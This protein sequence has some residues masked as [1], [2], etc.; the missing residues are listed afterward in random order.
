M[1]GL[2]QQFD[3]V[4][5]LS[6][7]V[8]AGKTVVPLVG[9]GFSVDSGIPTLSSLTQYL[10]KVQCY[11]ANEVFSPGA[12]E[13]VRVSVGSDETRAQS[14][15]DPSLYIRDIGWPDPHRMNAELWTWLE[16]QGRGDPRHRSLLDRQVQAAFIED[17]ARMDSGLADLLG[18]LP[19]W[20]RDLALKGNWKSLLAHL[21]RT[22]PD[23]VDTLFQ[24]LLKGRQPGTAH[25]FLAFLAPVLGLRLFLT[26]NF[27]DLLEQALRLAGLR[28]IVY[29][30]SRDS[31]LPHPSLIRQ[32]LSVVKL[33]GGA[34]GLRVGEELDHPL[35]EDSKR[36]LEQYLGDD[37]ILLVM[38]VGGWDRRVM[39]FVELVG[40]HPRSSGPAVYWMHFEPRCPTPIADL[41]KKI[42]E[43]RGVSSICPVRTYGPGAFLQELYY[44]IT[45]SHPPSVHSYDPYTTR[46]VDAFEHRAEGAESQPIH[47]FLDDPEDL[48]LDASLR[49]GRF[50][51]SKASTHV[52][53]WVD[54][55]VMHTLADVVAEIFRQIR[56]YDRWLSPIVL[57]TGPSPDDGDEIGKAVRRTYTALSRGRYILAFNAVGS[58]G[59]PPTYHHGFHERPG[60]D[61]RFF[62]ELFQA[63]H[64]PTE[65]GWIRPEHWPSFCGPLRDSILAF[66]I[67]PLGTRSP[68][69]ARDQTSGLPELYDLVKDADSPLCEP[70]HTPEPTDQ[71]RRFAAG[72]REVAWETEDFEILL[73]LAAFRRRRSIVALRRLIPA[74]VP[75]ELRGHRG[76]ALDAAVDD[77]LADL[78]KKGFVKRLEGGSYWMSPRMR[79]RIYELGQRSTDSER[80]AETIRQREAGDGT[81]AEPGIHLCRLATIHDQIADFY[82]AELFAAS[83]E[84]AALLECLYH[85][86]SSLRY[87]T[88][89]DVWL[90]G[91]IETLP[92]EAADRLRRYLGT[93]KLPAARARRRLRELRLRSLRSIRAVVAREREHLLSEVSTDTLIGWLEWIRD[94][95]L[96]RFRVDSCLTVENPPEPAR[97]GQREW[98]LEEAIEVECGE[99]RTL[100]DDLVA[101]ALRGKMDFAGCART[102]HRR[103]RLLLAPSLPD[104]ETAPPA[105]L[106][107][108]LVTIGQYVRSAEV[109]GRRQIVTA[110]CDLW[111]CLR[112]SGDTHY[113]DAVQGKWRGLVDHGSE[114]T[115]LDRGMEALRL[116]FLRAEAEHHLMGLSP[117]TDRRAAVPEL[118]ERCA[119]AFATCDEALQLITWATWA[120]DADYEREKSYFHSLKGRAHY[121]LRQ[122]TEAFREIDLS[123]MGLAPAIGAD[124]EVLAV[125]LLR[126]TE[127]LM[128]RSDQVFREVPAADGTQEGRGQAESRA[129]RHLSRAHD[130][131]E[132]AAEMMTGARQDVE[133]W[134]CLYQLRAQLQVEYLLLQICE[135]GEG[136]Q[137]RSRR[138]SAAQF[139]ERLRA[140]LRAIRQGLDVVPR[141]DRREDASL[142]SFIVARLLQAWVELMVCSAYLTRTI[143]RDP[144]ITVQDLWR[145]WRS[146]NEW[147][148]LRCCRTTG[149][150]FQ[151]LHE[152]SAP[153]RYDTGRE[154][155]DAAL[156][157]SRR[158]M[159]A[160]S[161]ERLFEAFRESAR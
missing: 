107:I 109:E 85:R 29:E 63:A 141:L 142:P 49:L 14:T 95:D 71:A 119:R 37:S 32:D 13:K 144:R 47:I 108:D 143:S 9:A 52:P 72:D 45:S 118:S 74:C 11:I 106:R 128:V 21:T 147:S 126:L 53:I 134:A 102:R 98:L 66:S 159:D 67:D 81:I 26:I 57:P 10:A 124:R 78:E 77:R 161:I 156:A 62:W 121:L 94:K 17:L 31:P 93:E 135:L 2:E 75:Q 7:E 69:E 64:R 139:T 55:E 20:T 38:G 149:D 84:A 153:R 35:D 8:K 76:E 133:W 54:L 136:G 114:G 122:V 150:F 56:R 41:A 83:R 59:R 155:R 92:A 12:Q 154:G 24:S 99:L 140:G 148:G 101:E 30:I 116:R 79:N 15:Y 132:R 39:D 103:I 130:V 90:P 48:S 137:E 129:Q 5:R 22:N 158:C 70:L 123:Q 40:Q 46:P 125:G 58:F 73:L 82:Y 6:S 117:W 138:Q 65:G 80:L 3:L 36:R 151:G 89:L 146:L 50:V 19:A 152:S 51:S 34:F 61:R 86:T 23:Y 104:L 33:H 1:T 68:L 97:G 111:V 120:T 115:P 28:P 60:K 25:R 131:L 127:L 110:L 44:R 145:R 157:W 43:E 91:R 87:L 18:N 4:Q 105:D 27:D 160:G 113:G 42:K 88:K 100:L 96:F 16:G 112:R